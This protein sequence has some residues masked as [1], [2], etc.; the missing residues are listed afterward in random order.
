MREL[1]EMLGIKTKLSTAFHPQ[2][3]G[4]TERMNQELEQYLRMFIDHCQDH[5]PEW[6][7][8]AEF[9]YNNKV[10]A[11]TK[12]SPFE[13]NSGQNPRMGFELRKK[14]KFE[15]AEKFAKRMKE[16]QE[17]AKAA[18]GKAQEDMR[19]YADRHRGET[20]GYKVGDLVLLST[21]DLKWQMVGR[22]SEKLVEW[23]VGPYKI[24][25][26][27]SSNVVELELPA[28]IKIH[29]VVNVSQIKRYIDQVDGQKETPQPVIIEGEKEWE[30]EKILNKR[31]IRGKDKFLVRWKG[32]TTEGDTWES[33]EN[34]QNAGESL[35]EF[36]EEY[37]KDN[38]EVRRQEGVEEDK[39]YWRGGFPGW[40]AARRLFG[41]SDGEYDCQYWQRL[42]RNWKQW[43]NVK[44]AGKEKGRLTAVCEVAEEEEGKIKEWNEEDEMGN[45][46]DPTEEL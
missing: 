29:P 2:T 6:L 9:A 5:W 1:N 16:V 40:Y 17:E 13:A 41:W 46:G 8:T 19:R 12:V 27:I 35:R 39:D 18:L 31:R 33:R 11:G 34:L 20:V 37:R 15:G 24:K 28:S 36:E 32:F 14:G 10:H 3:G 43:K 25:A 23:F 4:Q 42:E 44:P 45:M 21:K 7:G 26:I 38:R 30:V 22:Q